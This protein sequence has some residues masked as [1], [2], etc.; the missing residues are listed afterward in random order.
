MRGFLDADHQIILGL[1]LIIIG[2]GINGK[3]L[4]IFTTTLF[5]GIPQIKNMLNSIFSI[6][7]GPFIIGIADIIQLIGLV[8]FL[9]GVR[10]IG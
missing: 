2:F 8:L 6:P 4:V 1:I 5:S 7:M 9:N 3:F 10:V